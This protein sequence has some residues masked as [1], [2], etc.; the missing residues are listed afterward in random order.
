MPGTL[1]GLPY[2]G[3][4]VFF[5]PPGRRDIAAVLA[6]LYPAATVLLGLIYLKGKIVLRAVGGNYRC[7]GGRDPDRCLKNA[8]V[9]Y[10]LK[11]KVRPTVNGRR[12]L[13]GRFAAPTAYYIPAP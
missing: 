12:C 11:A 3:A 10:I 9:S 8:W 1:A 2:T 7:P 5:S 6:S 4:M 13:D